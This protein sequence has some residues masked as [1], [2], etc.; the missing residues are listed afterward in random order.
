MILPEH[1]FPLFDTVHF[2]RW[3]IYVTMCCVIF[4]GIYLVLAEQIPP[5]FL[6]RSRAQNQV[7]PGCC[8]CCCCLLRA[9]CKGSHICLSQSSPPTSVQRLH[10]KAKAVR[11]YDLAMAA[12]T[13]PWF[14]VQVL[15]LNH[16]GTNFSQDE[17]FVQ[18][19]TF[20]SSRSPPKASRFHPVEGHQRL[21]T[22]SMDIVRST[23]DDPSAGW[24][25]FL[26]R[27]CFCLADCCTINNFSVAVYETLCVAGTGF[28]P[29]TQEQL[30]SS[31]LLSSS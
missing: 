8:C 1:I 9:V 31:P 6:V 13:H 18:P 25:S 21:Y 26:Y 3:S 14:L 19:R 15:V 10:E 28:P 22:R 12:E 2:R 4:Y 17:L 5:R 29:Y 20:A 30:L 23:S 27:Y 16:V 24:A 11:M 7:P